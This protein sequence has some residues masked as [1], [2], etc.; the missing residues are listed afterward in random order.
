[1]VLPTWCR[2]CRVTD[3]V[4]SGGVTV[5]VSQKSTGRGDCRK[6]GGQVAIAMSGYGSLAGSNLCPE[7]EPSMPL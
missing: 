4:S 7:P 6:I 3:V 2:W 5:G 1:M